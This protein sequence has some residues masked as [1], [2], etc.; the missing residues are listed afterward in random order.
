MFTECESY[1]TLMSDVFNV[2]R[3]YLA[4]L[5]IDSRQQVTSLGWAGAA[6]GPV[7]DDAEA[8]SGSGAAGLVTRW[9]PRPS[10]PPEPEPDGWGWGR[11][12]GE[13]REHLTITSQSCV[14]TRRGWS[15]TD[16]QQGPSENR[17]RSV[18]KVSPHFLFSF[19][20]KMNVQKV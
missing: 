18:W 20:L 5:G 2:Y 16:Q 4:A 7:S 17:H 15:D 14:T 19:C 1:T 11:Q 9:Q 12:S 8:G 10:T 3:F 13:Q 6:P